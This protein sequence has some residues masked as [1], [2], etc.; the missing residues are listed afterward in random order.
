MAAGLGIIASDT[1]TMRRLVEE[2]NIGLLTR[3]TN[4]RVTSLT[5]VFQNL[6][7]EQI[8]TW[9]ENSHIQASQTWLKNY[10]WPKLD[11]SLRQIQQ[12]LTTTAN[13]K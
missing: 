12:D 1:P 2:Q 4:E 3:I 9:Q 13:K 7:H 8:S 6:S 5:Q 11:S 10:D